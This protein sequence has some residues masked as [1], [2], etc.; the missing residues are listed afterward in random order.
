VGG[1][2]SAFKAFGRQLCCRP[3]AKISKMKKEN[4]FKKN[5]EKEQALFLK[6]CS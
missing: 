1:S 4:Y 3:K 2:K 6:G 5:N